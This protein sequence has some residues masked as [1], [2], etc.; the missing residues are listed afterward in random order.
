MLV[1]YFRSQEEQKE[2]REKTLEIFKSLILLWKNILEF[3]LLRFGRKR[4]KNLFPKKKLKIT[5]IN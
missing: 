5:K 1:N 2:F 3:S 4:W